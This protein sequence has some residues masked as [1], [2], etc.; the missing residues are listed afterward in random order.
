MSKLSYPSNGLLSYCNGNLESSRDNLSNARNNCS[1]DIP[2]DFPYRNYL[3][4]LY[5]TLDSYVNELTN[6]KQV[7][8]N[9]DKNFENLSTE[10][11]NDVN[12]MDKSI[13]NVRDRLI[14]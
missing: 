6:I 4:G 11:T 3:S 5:D 9:V 7:I 14:K 8:M 2:V 10:L 12:N 1:F 13:I